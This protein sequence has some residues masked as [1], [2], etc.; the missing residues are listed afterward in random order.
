MPYRFPFRAG[1]LL[2]TLLVLA[3][4]ACSGTWAD[5]PTGFTETRLVTGIPGPTALEILPDGRIL[6]TEQVGRLRVIKNGVLLPT[7]FLQVTV[8]PSGERGLLGVTVDPNFP[9]SPYVYVYYTTPT[10]VP[11]N[12]I[13]R[14][15]A[16]GDVAVPG[17]EVVLLELNALSA[18][19]IHNG[20]ALHFGKD[21][22]LY[23]AVGENGA[24]QNAQRLDNLLGKILR[25]HKDGTIPEDNPFYQQATGNNRAIWALG[26]RNP[27]TFGVDRETGR[28]FINDVGQNTWEE[29]NDGVPGGNY[30]W[31]TLEGPSNN[32]NF[33]APLYAYHHTVGQ[34]VGCAI[35]GGDF[36]R[37]ATVR[38]PAEYVGK[39]FFADYCAGWIRT[40]DPA[41]GVSA[42]FAEG[43]G[44]PT[45][46]RVGP[47]GSLYVLT[48]RSGDVYRIDYGPAQ[49]PSILADPE[50]ITVAVGQTATFSVSASGAVPLAYQWFRN[51][52]PLSGANEAH[53]TAPPVSA[54]DNGARFRVVVTNRSGTA[55]SAEAVLTVTP[56]TAP[57]AVILTPQPGLRY[58]G[59]DTVEF[60]GTGTDAEDGT[61][62]P[63]RYTWSVEFHHDD[64]THPVVPPTSGV[65]GGSFTIPTTG[66]TSAN[67]WYRVHLTV[68]DSAGLTD[69]TFVDVLPR[70]AEVTL[71]SN[72]P[73]LTLLL[74]GQPVTT[75]FSF[76][77]VTGIVRT[78][79]PLTPQERQGERYRFS[80]WADSAPAERALSTPAADLTLTANF[81]LAAPDA[82]TGF[83]AEVVSSSR[84]RLAW[85]EASGT[86]LELERRI[87]N[88]PFARIA[89]LPATAREYL[90]TGLAAR[91]RCAY[92]LRA[93][94]SGGPSEYTPVVEVQ[95]PPAGTLSIKPA[96]VDFGTVP[97]GQP[98]TRSVTLKNT[99]RYP[100]WLNVGTP[101]SPFQVAPVGEAVLAPGATRVLTVQFT[102][103]AAGKRT[104][105]LPLS[106]DAAGKRSARVRLTGK[107]RASGAG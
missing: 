71:Q 9:E 104:G 28:L 13:S 69:E 89:T 27:F 90:D 73:G 64:H 102:A 52:Q 30:G 42:P 43:Y 45:D 3:L 98:A 4:A 66:E 96:Q 84:V 35:S 63:A 22:L 70:T 55:T 97:V 46:L 88:R 106:S 79:A 5:P 47:D 67:V 23:A 29:V 53:Y 62:P 16:N 33:R 94:N 87:N 74:D 81:Q 2:L 38:F 60:S 83:T 105:A 91:T 76:T 14:F 12:R 21:G 11:H 103:P 10:P 20:G 58:R 77:G 17:S 100:V 34:P 93:V 40:L 44:L 59:G 49:E 107:G 36:Y 56:N 26:L 39:Y 99:G 92:R 1:L 25:L 37:P 6:V 82:P 51:N 95:T 32:P 65:A 54:A 80:G 85:K 18:A 101:G 31:P 48:R 75:P 15:T 19:Q 57:A 24:G 86:Q 41:T 78:L 7:P 68:Q 50:S 72:P 61:L 8:D